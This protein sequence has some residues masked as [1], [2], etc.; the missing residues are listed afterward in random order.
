ME[1]CKQ[2]GRRIVN[3]AEEHTEYD[4]DACFY[5]FNYDGDCGFARLRNCEKAL[6]KILRLKGH[7]ASTMTEVRK[8]VK[9]ALYPT[10]KKA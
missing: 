10:R 4:P 8:L 1:R 6:R 2:C 7:E 5:L 3:S 9:A